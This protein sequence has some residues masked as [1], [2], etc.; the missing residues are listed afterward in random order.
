MLR[1]IEN[2][3]ERDATRIVGTF[4]YSLAGVE[5]IDVGGEHERRRPDAL[6]NPG[7]GGRVGLVDADLVIG[8]HVG[9]RLQ[10]APR[11]ARRTLGPDE[12]TMPGLPGNRTTGAG[13]DERE[14]SHGA[15]RG[16]SADDEATAQDVQNARSCVKR[17]A[18]AIGAIL[19]QT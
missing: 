10:I 3:V 14:R 2:V 8:E 16:L 5:H 15:G 11:I 9:Q 18:R 12:H 6:G 17:Q 1:P 19:A 13:E 7:I 4:E